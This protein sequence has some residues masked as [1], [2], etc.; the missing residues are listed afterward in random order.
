MKETL[1]V[2]DG[3][4]TFVWNQEG[5]LSCLRY[6]EPWLERFEGGSN[7][8]LQ[9]FF[10]AQQMADLLQDISHDFDPDKTLG[11][12]CGPEMLNRIK[13]LF[14]SIKVDKIA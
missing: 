7:A 9:L 6:D 4:Y 13:T 1:S 14:E 12:P 3:K 11:P 2:Y 5:G 10:A 8:V